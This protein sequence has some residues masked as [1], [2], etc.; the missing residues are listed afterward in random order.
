MPIY[1]Y[2]CQK[3]SEVYEMLRSISAEDTDIVCP[4][5]GAKKKAKKLISSFS[6]SSETSLG[7][8]SCE[9]ASTCG[10]AGF[11]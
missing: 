11:T 2:E 8:G 3:C 7:G 1:E 4:E 5:C 6:S 9:H 10:S